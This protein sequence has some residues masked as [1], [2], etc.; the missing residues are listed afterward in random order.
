MHQACTGGNKKS[1]IFCIM[2]SLQ[3]S[4]GCAKIRRGDVA[5]AAVFNRYA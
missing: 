4:Y 3:M 2:L 1:R 5:V